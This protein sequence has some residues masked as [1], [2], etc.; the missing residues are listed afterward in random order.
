MTG[1]MSLQILAAATP[2]KS[3]N[4]GLG[5]IVVFFIAIGLFVLL[6]SMSKHLRKVDKM[7]AEGV[8]D[9]QTTSSTTPPPRDQ[10]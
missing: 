1:V 2:T 4:G 9:Q 8:F 5:L 6:R 7:K 10:L 3:A